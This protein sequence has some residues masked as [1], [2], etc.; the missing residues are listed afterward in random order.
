MW[1]G[2]ESC[3]LCH[4]GRT[5]S[6]RFLPPSPP[7]PQGPQGVAPCR[8]GGGELNKLMPACT[9]TG[10]HLVSSGFSGYLCWHGACS[11]PPKLEHSEK[12]GPTM[13]ILVKA[14]VW[15]HFSL[16]GHLSLSSN[17]QD[18]MSNCLHSV[19]QQESLFAPR[20]SVQFTYLFHCATSYT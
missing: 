20:E 7:Y 17:V 2:P 14:K 1:S 18:A 3:P 10:M 13:L 4:F 15:L 16:N 12:S 5:R 6:V 8:Q 11:V 19:F 9:P